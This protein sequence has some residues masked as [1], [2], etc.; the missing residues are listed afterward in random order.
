[1]FHNPDAVTFAATAA[2]TARSSIVVKL[3]AVEF[4]EMVVPNNLCRSIAIVVDL[5]IEWSCHTSYDK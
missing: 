4:G 3:E 1:M 2:P 5:S